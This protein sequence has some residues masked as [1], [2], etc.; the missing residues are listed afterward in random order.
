G[1]SKAG[2]VKTTTLNDLGISVSAIKLSPFEI[3][4]NRSTRILVAVKCLK[5]GQKAKNN[6]RNKN[7]GDNNIGIS[8]KGNLNWGNNNKGINQRCNN[9]VGTRKGP[10]MCSLKELHKSIVKELRQ[11][12]PPPKKNQVLPSPTGTMTW[13]GLKFNYAIDT[14]SY[15]AS[16]LTLVTFASDNTVLGTYAAKP[17]STVTERT[18]TALPVVAKLFAYAK[19]FSKAGSVRTSTL[20]ILG[21]SM[22]AVRMSTAELV[23]PRSTKVIVAVE[24]LKPGQT[25]CTADSSGNIGS[26]NRGKRNFG[27]NNVGDDNIGNRNTGSSN[28][29]DNN[30]GTSNRCF[31]KVGDRKVVN[32]CKLTEFRERAF[33]V[34]VPSPP[35]KNQVLPSPTGTM[36]WTDLYFH[37]T[38]DTGSYMASTI[39]IV[40]FASD[41]TALVSYTKDPTST[42]TQGTYTAI[43]TVAKLFAYAKASAKITGPPEQHSD[44]VLL[45]P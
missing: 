39:T 21:L 26:G 13:N 5:A 15:I 44:F 43:P 45:T 17:T 25:A 30:K 33:N 37:F 14:G 10:N 3:I 35:P 42:V 8:N 19:G 27:T 24:C 20:N 4:K 40:L 41:D 34:I 1:Y 6:F 22:D 23:T 9:A 31:D 29:G 12:P 38:V 2:S 11:P 28:W 32:D 36:A 7:V 16:S 18:A